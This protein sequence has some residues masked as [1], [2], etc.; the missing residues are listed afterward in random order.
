[1]D[2][3]FRKGPVLLVG[4]GQSPC[5]EVSTLAVTAGTRATR[6]CLV[7]RGQGGERPLCSER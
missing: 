6:L 7:A 1:M 5:S 3:A 4:P 2:G